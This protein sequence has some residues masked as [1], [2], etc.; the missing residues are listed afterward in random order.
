MDNPNDDHYYWMPNVKFGTLRE[1]RLT[2]N[3]ISPNAMSTLF[4]GWKMSSRE[5]AILHFFSFPRVKDER[6]E[7][8]DN[9]VGF[10]MMNLQGEFADKPLLVVGPA[11]LLVCFFLLGGK[12]PRGCRR[13]GTRL[14]ARE[15]SVTLIPLHSRRYLLDV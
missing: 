6:D 8:D 11:P 7:T 5:N 9:G 12:T 2:T 4:A 14:R 10:L 15:G 3:A 1:K 13:R